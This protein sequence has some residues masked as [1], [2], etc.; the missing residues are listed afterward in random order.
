MAAVVFVRYDSAM[1]LGAV[2]SRLALT[3][4]ASLLA[5]CAF[6]GPASNKASSGTS[7]TSTSGS[8]VAASGG[9]TS[10]GAG[11]GSSGAL[12]PSGASSGG[13]PSGTSATA[14]PGTSGTVAS[15]SGAEAD[16]DLDAGTTSDETVDASADS[17]TYA[18]WVL[19]WSDEFNGE[20]GTPPDPKYWSY[21]LGGGGWGVG[22]LQVYT[23]NAANAETDGLGNLQMTVIEDAK[24]NFTSARIK[25]QN[26][27]QQAYGRFEIRAK[28]VTG[29]GMWPAF[30]MLGDNYDTAGWPQCGEMDIME[31]RGSTPWTNGGSLHGPGYSG[32]HPLSKAFTLP[33]GGP[34]LS[35]DF[36]IFAIEWETN[37]VRFYVDTNLYETETPADIPSGAGPWVYDHPF[38]I[39][40]NL[41][42]GGTPPWGPPTGTVF[43]ETMLVDYIR[44]YSRPDA[45]P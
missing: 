5:A 33:E 37:V 30:W 10:G 29:N 26:K 42:V 2:L 15:S 34:K 28:V 35:D 40:V 32:M 41:A 22:Q 4:A 14:P 45:G 3:T 19:S 44:V 9:A 39:L 11:A 36:H 23:N 20:A 1:K 38:F 17:S 31:V 25:T 21:D 16:N 43:P 8:I 7:G 6:S 13:V 24:G 27:F 18:D 12:A